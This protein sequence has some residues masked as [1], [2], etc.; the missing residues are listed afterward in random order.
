M[1]NDTPDVAGP[2]RDMDALVIGMPDYTCEE[3]SPEVFNLKEE[4]GQQVKLVWSG[5][6][7]KPIRLAPKLTEDCAPPD[8][9]DMPSNLQF[10]GTMVVFEKGGGYNLKEGE[11]IY[12]AFKGPCGEF[13]VSEVRAIGIKLKPHGFSEAEIQA[14]IET[15][16]FGEL[17]ARI[18]IWNGNAQLV[19]F[20]GE[21]FLDLVA[22]MQVLV[23][24]NLNIHEAFQWKP[25]PGEDVS[26]SEYASDASMVN[27]MIHNP[28]NAGGCQAET[29]AVPNMDV[30]VTTIGVLM[31]ARALRAG[32]KL[33][34][35]LRTMA[36]LLGLNKKKD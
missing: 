5:G 9:I 28:K 27:T 1:P 16:D 21:E 26:S 19:S 12:Q 31:I 3:F 15:G 22:G 11:M 24:K 6:S 35:D 4:F 17:L 33:P 8:I 36:G 13:P 29:R 20:D 32:I 14:K 7:C 34:V 25:E 18:H 2:D 30:L 10:N 23:D